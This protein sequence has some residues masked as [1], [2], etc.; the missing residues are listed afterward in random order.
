MTDRSARSGRRGLRVLEAIAGLL[1][2]GML[3]LGLVLLA[4]KAFAPA[5]LG[6]HGLERAQG[7]A[8][9]RLLLVLLAGA[10]GE[11]AHVARTR[12]PDS[13]RWVLG[14]GV[15]VVAFTALWVTFWR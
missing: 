3:V 7:P 4:A 9:W 6:G 11:V 14:V 13:A 12:F 1:A 15:T 5:L 8:W 2:A 10:L